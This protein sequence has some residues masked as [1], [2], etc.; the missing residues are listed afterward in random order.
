MRIMRAKF[1]IIRVGSYKCGERAISV[2]TLV[3]FWNG[4][5]CKFME[6]DINRDIYIS[7]QK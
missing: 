1:L 5:L 2:N 4:M 3:L 7:P 6:I